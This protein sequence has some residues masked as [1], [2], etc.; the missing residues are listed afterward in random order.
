MNLDEYKPKNVDVGWFVEQEEAKFVFPEPITLFK[1]RKKLFPTERFK[2]VL[3]L[4]NMKEI[5]L[6]LGTLLI[7]DLDV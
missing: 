2:L 6:L 5:Y 4:M 1:S 7:L 3:P